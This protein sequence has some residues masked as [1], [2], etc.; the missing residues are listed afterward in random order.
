MELHCRICAQ[1]DMR[2]CHVFCVFETWLTSNTPDSAIQQEGSSV[3]R[4]DRWRDATGKSEG[5]GVYFLVSNSWCTDVEVISHSCPLVLVKCCPF[6]SPREFP[7]VLLTAAYI[8]PQ[9]NVAA[10]EELYGAISSYVDQHPQAIFI[11]ARDFN[12]CNLKSVLLK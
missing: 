10:L 2:N 7:T 8:P 12:H 9:A 5:G 11:V 4:L 1:G 3:H 6:Y